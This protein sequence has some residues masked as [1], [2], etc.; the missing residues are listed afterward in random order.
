M[1]AELGR[2]RAERAASALPRAA[3]EHLAEPSRGSR[4]RRGGEAE[5]AAAALRAELRGREKE[6]RM[7]K[8]RAAAAV[9]AAAGR[10][11]AEAAARERKRLCGTSRRRSCA[12]RTPSARSTRCASRRSER[13]C[14]RL[15]REKSERTLAL[16]TE[17]LRSE[18]SRSRAGSA[19]R[20][21]DRARDSEIARQ[22]GSADMEGTRDD[23]TQSPARSSSELSGWSVPERVWQE[24]LLE[25]E[26]ALSALSERDKARE[27]ELTRLRDRLARLERRGLKEAK[28]ASTPSPPKPPVGSRSRA[29]TPNEDVADRRATHSRTNENAIGAG[30]SLPAIDVSRGT[31]KV[32]RAQTRRPRRQPR[33]RRRARG[34]R[35]PRGSRG[36]GSPPRGSCSGSSRRS[37]RVSLCLE[38]MVGIT[39]RKLPLK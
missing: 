25:K 1:K 38:W 13:R 14:L 21:D 33:P 22:R 2:M 29:V 7:E 15:E 3:D 23:R 17:E 27:D 10:A 34:R 9:A 39:N 36:W 4:G 32:F 26:S 6:L 11:A 18:R 16:V 37:S 12:P 20:A 31:R 19:S 30:V 5:A 28:E 24:I 35:S 8:R